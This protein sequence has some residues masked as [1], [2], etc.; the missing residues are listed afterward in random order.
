MGFVSGS[1]AAAAGI[2]ALIAKLG[3][4]AAAKGAATQLAI[5][6]LAAAGKAAVGQGARMAGSGAFKSGLGKALFGEMSKGQIAGRLAP[7]AAFGGMSA[8]MTPGDLGDKLIAG[9]TQAIGGG[10][11][12]LLL[13]ELLEQLILV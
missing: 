13:V 2:K 11:G 7:D 3:M 8:V 4:G 10:L 12:G 1:L 6:G 5:P 9:S